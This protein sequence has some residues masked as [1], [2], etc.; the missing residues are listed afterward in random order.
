[1]SKEADTPGAL[2]K[3]ARAGQRNG[4]LVKALEKQ[5]SVPGWDGFI[6]TRTGVPALGT[7]D[8]TTQREGKPRALQS[9]KESVQVRDWVVTRGSASA[10]APWNAVATQKKDENP[11]SRQ[12]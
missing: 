9:H 6:W 3:D 7:G 12:N 8:M 1:M 5:Q 4:R 10:N 2:D 11:Q